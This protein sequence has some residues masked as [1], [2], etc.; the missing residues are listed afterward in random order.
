MNIKTQIAV[1]VI[2]LLA[3]FSLVNRIRKNKLELKYS[4]LW[5]ALGIGVIVFA[6]IPELTAWLAKCLGIGQPINLLFFAGF[7]F[8]LMIIYALTGAVSRMS[9]KMKRLTQEMGLLKKEMEELERYCR[10]L[11]NNKIK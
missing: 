2:V 4:F 1:V 9:V 10:E 3:M 11:K 6:L 7:C 8:A 5:F